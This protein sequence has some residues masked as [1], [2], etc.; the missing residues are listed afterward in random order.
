MSQQLD[1]AK[2]IDIFDTTRKQFL[3]DYVPLIHEQLQRVDK[4]SKLVKQDPSTMCRVYPK[5]EHILS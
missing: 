5:N 3:D 4:C 1:T 2:L